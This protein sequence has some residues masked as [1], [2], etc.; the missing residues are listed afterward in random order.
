MSDE[1]P[2]WERQ[3]GETSLRYAAF[4]RYRDMGPEERSLAKVAKEMAPA[5]TRLKLGQLKDWSAWDKWQIRVRAW[6]DEQD[7][8]K[9]AYMNKALKGQ[10]RKYLDIAITAQSKGVK[11]LQAYNPDLEP[12]KPLESMRFINEAVKLECLALGV[13]SEIVNV[14][15]SGEVKMKSCCMFLEELKEERAKFEQSNNTGEKDQ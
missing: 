3:D 13:P 11:S 2:L 6:D 9:R 12:M 14:Q 10:A 7:R 5:K 8:I 15:H 4:C 1:I